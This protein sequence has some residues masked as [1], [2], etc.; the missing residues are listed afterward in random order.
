MSAGSSVGLTELGSGWALA[1]GEVGGSFGAESY[2]LLANPGSADASVTLT[3]YR[4]AGRPALTLERSVPA[5]T[6]VTVPASAAGLDSERFG[7][8]ISSTQPIAVERSIYWN[9]G[10]PWGSGTNETGARIR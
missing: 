3:F 4:E 1:E 10:G 5:G 8:V 2:I 6:R 7:A 9:Q